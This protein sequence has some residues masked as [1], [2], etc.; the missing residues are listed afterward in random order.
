MRSSG[1]VH[2]TYNSARNVY[3]GSSC[4]SFRKLLLDAS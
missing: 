4:G 3:T 1:Y 2:A